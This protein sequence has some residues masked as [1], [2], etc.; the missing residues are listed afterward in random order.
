MAARIRYEV[1][2]LTAL[3]L[4]RVLVVPVIFL[5]FELRQDYIAR[6]L[7]ENRHRPELHCD[8][9]CYLAKR[10]Q[11]TQEREQSEKGQELGRYLFETP[12]VATTTVFVFNETPPVPQPLLPAYS[13]RYPAGTRPALLQPPRA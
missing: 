4:V 2:L 7:C 13:A 3:L 9:Q 5:H 6:Y 11:A 1:L 8:G 10:L 12:F